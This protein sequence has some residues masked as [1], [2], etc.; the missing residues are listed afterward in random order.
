MELSPI[1]TMPSCTG[2]KVGTVSEGIG[3]ASE[4]IT[5]SKCFELLAQ[6]KENQAMGN[7]PCTLRELRAQAEAERAIQKK[8]ADRHDVTLV[9]AWADY[10]EDRR[11]KWSD[12]HLTDHL[13][14]ASAGGTKRKRGK[15]KTKPGPLAALMGLKLSELTPERVET[16]A[17]SESKKRETRT[18]L[19][20][21]LLRAFIYWTARHPDYRG[22][23]SIEACT[24]R[25]RR[26]IFP[27]KRAKDDCLQKEQLKSWFSAVRGLSNP[28]VSAYL[29]TLLLTGARREE[30][31]GLNGRMWISNGIQ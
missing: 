19:S 10:I 21:S 2:G 8:E 17:A 16:W 12:R 7:G 9:A 31:A 1:D 28:V 5:P 11:S 3:W 24:N 29:Q 14:L 23:A 15:G 26:E 20:F 27:K 30:L 13:D 6:I 25:I 22:L 18:R 4:K